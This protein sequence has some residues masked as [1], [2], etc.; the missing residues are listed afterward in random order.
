GFEIPQQQLVIALV[1]AGGLAKRN[2]IFLHIRQAHAKVV[3]LHARVAGA[4]FAGPAIV[5]AGQKAAGLVAFFHIRIDARDELVLGRIFGLHAIER[6][7]VLG[8]RL[9]TN[10]VGDAGLGHQI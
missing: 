1:V 10:R 2:L 5:Q 7:A 3:G 9:A 6:F 8:I 4:F